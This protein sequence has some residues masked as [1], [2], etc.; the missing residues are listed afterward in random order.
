MG[1]GMDAEQRILEAYA[2]RDRRPLDAFFGYSELGHVVRVQERHRA[3]LRLLA[4][5]GFGDLREAR[6]LD[7][8]CGDGNM[9]R[10][11]I[12]WGASPNHVAGID[13]RSDAIERARERSPHIDAR[14]GSAASLPWDPG[15]FDIVLLHTVFSS[16]LESGLRRSVALE[17]LRVLADRGIVIW[18]DLRVNNPK[19][20]AVRGLGRRDI[21]SLFAPHLVRLR[22]LSLAPPIAR[23]VPNALL[24]TV[25]P[26]LAAIP[27]LR[28]HYLGVVRRTG[29]I[30]AAK[31]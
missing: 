9:L 3:T 17:S 16:I 27:F 23:R 19:N 8:G 31:R 18:Y 30:D 2:E 15:A 21:E 25:Y 5:E 4:A 7:I 22:S 28:S 12:E 11:C 10:Q 14:V 6:I 29:D 26:L 1:F 13:L 20:R 24:S